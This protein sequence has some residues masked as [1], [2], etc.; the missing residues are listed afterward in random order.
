M[1][2]IFTL[3]MVLSG[4]YSFGQVQLDSIVQ[5][6]PL[7]NVVYE[8]QSFEYQNGVL[9]KYFEGYDDYV[10]EVDIMYKDNGDYILW[11]VLD[12]EDEGTFQFIYDA[13]DNLDSVVISYLGQLTTVLDYSFTNNVLESIEFSNV[14]YDIPELYIRR[15]LDFTSGVLVAYR[16]YDISDIEEELE[17]DYSLIYDS[18]SRLVKEVLK[19]DGGIF[20][21]DSLS[22]D[23]EGN[24]KDLFRLEYQGGSFVG[25]TQLED[26]SSDVTYKFDDI[27]SPVKFLEFINHYGN[28][29]YIDSYYPMKYGNKVDQSITNDYYYDESITKWYY[30]GI[31]GTNERVVTTPISVYPNPTSDLIRI[32]ND[33]I[34]TKYY[35][36][37]AGGTLISE[38]NPTVTNTINV[39]HFPTGSYTIICANQDNKHYFAQFVKQ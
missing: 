21:V 10:V 27:L 6:D 4:L 5:S 12:D 28:N 35:I 29:E 37:N 38:S 30:S 36:Y 22:Y 13:E 32:E 24:I 34:M 7:T 31:V 3:I 25:I 9:T 11:N 17:T 15:D 19:D 16:D 23:S 18:E 8:K 33:E 2:S 26:Y 1:K 20:Q 14:D 39:S